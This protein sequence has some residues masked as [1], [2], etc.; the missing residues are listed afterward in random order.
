MLKLLSS[1]RITVVCLFLLF[2]LIFWG[3]VA[4]VQQGLYVAQERFFNSFF[5]LADGFLPFPG[6]QLVLWVLF[7]NLLAMTITRFSTYRKWSYAGVLIVHFGLLLYFAA[8]FIV[9]QVSRESNVHLTEGEAT[10]VSTSYIQWELAYWTGPD[11]TIGAGESQHHQVTAVDTNDFKPGYEIP[12]V[13]KDFALKVK[14]F[15]PNSDAF[16]SSEKRSPRILNASGISLLTPKPL[17]KERGQNIAGGIFDVQFKSHDYTLILFGTESQAT[18]VTIGDKVYHFSL[19][20]KRYLLP[21]TI[22][23]DHFKVE[24][25]PGTDMA[26][27]YESLVTLSTGALQRQVRIFMNNPLR[28]KDYTLYQASYD[29]D[30][31][32]RQ[33][34]TLAVVKNFARLLPYVACFIVFFG[35]ALHFLTQA[36]LVKEET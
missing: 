31:V 15:Y 1:V 28:Y 24:F 10:N 18:A 27:S 30:S 33:Y 13:N 11:G 34:T 20:H 29:V 22:K 2:V 5:F 8:A 3:T 17:L 16:S 21:F 7:V 14:Q 9:F 25:H 19:R 4:Q 12:F 26:K 23:L 35:L 32:G 6:A 36:F